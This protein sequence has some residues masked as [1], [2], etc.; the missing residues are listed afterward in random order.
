VRLADNWDK[1]FYDAEI[2]EELELRPDHNSWLYE[3]ETMETDLRQKQN[4]GQT[5]P[6]QAPP[7]Q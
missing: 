3:Q 5:A 1:A 2:I 4:A 7:K 6:K